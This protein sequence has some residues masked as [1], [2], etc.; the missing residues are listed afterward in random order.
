VRRPH[1]SIFALAA[2]LTAG[3]FAQLKAQNYKGIEVRVSAVERATTVSL[4]DCPG[5]GQ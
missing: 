3:A 4:T 5:G 2:I 1:L